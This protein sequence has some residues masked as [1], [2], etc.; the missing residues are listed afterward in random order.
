MIPVGVMCCVEQSRV[1]LLP[2]AEFAFAYNLN[3]TNIMNTF[4]FLLQ[5][6]YNSKSGMNNDKLL[7]CTVT[8]IFS[9]NF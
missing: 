6:E 1:V 4:V 2:P 9:N 7:L 3:D 8:I 5:E